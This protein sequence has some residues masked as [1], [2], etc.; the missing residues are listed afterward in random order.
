MQATRELLDLKPAAI[1]HIDRILFERTRGQLQFQS[2][3]DLMELNDRPCESILLVEFFEDIDE[4]LAELRRIGQQIARRLGDRVAE[5]RIV[6][7]CGEFRE[8]AETHLAAHIIDD[9]RTEMDEL[10]TAS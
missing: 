8:I 4:R 5:S 6:R 3:R 2:A 10:R 1:E 9:F 7:L